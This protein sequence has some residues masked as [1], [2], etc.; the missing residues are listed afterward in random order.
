MT[1]LLSA[2]FKWGHEAIERFGIYFHFLAWTIPLLQTIAV[3]LLAKIDGNELTG[4]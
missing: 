4:L 1:F 3:L 2:G